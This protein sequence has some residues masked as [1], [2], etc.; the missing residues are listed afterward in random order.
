MRVSERFADQP[1]TTMSY[2]RACIAE[3]R[4][5]RRESHYRNRKT[6]RERDTAISYVFV[7]PHTVMAHIED[8]TAAKQLRE[9][10]AQKPA[11]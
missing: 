11:A 10:Q 3:Q 4:T 1:G 9:A 5:L 6:G 8:I 7:P 2:L